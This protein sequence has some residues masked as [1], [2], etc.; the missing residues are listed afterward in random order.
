M[1]D[2]PYRPIDGIEKKLNVKNKIKCPI[3][4][5]PLLHSSKLYK[6]I[7]TVTIITKN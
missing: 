5:F 3:R 1:Q 7:I 6:K 2:L 4:T